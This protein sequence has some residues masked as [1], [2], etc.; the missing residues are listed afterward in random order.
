MLLMKTA[1]YDMFSVSH[2]LKYKFAFFWHSFDIFILRLR[3]HTTFMK[4]LE[5]FNLKFSFLIS[6]LFLKKKKFNTINVWD[7]MLRL[8]FLFRMRNILQKKQKLSVEHFIQV[9]SAHVHC[10]WKSTKII[11]HNMNEGPK[12]LNNVKC[13]WLETVENLF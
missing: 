12:K 3:R 6:V 10:I 11:Y 5:R 7:G 2:S 9:Y 4:D 13:I 8:Q 1:Y